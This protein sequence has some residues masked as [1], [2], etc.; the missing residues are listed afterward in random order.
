MTGQGATYE[1]EAMV[2]VCHCNAQRAECDE[3]GRG[4]NQ[5]VN[6]GRPPRFLSRN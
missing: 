4:Y 2:P 1:L 6:S 5:E 3:C